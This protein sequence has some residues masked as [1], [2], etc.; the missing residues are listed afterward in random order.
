M[1]LAISVSTFVVIAPS[2][3]GVREF[4]IAITLVG[5]GVP[6]GVAYG[7]ALASRLIATVADVAA[8]GTAALLAVRQLRRAPARA[9]E[10]AGAGAAER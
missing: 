1:A 5:F 2:G 3:I 6:F 8:A 7:I 9:A 10:T 4:L